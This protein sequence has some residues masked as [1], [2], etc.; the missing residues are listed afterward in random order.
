MCKRCQ[1]KRTAWYATA[2]PISPDFDGEKI[3]EVDAAI[4]AT[5]GEKPDYQAA[6]AE[7]QRARKMCKGKDDA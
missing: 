3:G 7:Y 1:E 5:D 2:T 4:V 6:L